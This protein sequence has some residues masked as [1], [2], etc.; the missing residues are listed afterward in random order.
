MVILQHWGSLGDVFHFLGR[1][2][3][4]S[5]GSV[6]TFAQSKL[7]R[8]LR[9]CWAF[10]WSWCGREYKQQGIPLSVLCLDFCLLSS[11]FPFPLH[12]SHHMIRIATHLY[13]MQASWGTVMS[14]KYW[15]KLVQTWMRRI[16]CVFCSWSLKPAGVHSRFFWLVYLDEKDESGTSG[17]N[18]ERR[19]I[20]RKPSARQPILF[21]FCFFSRLL[22]LALVLFSWFYL[23]S[24]FIWFCWSLSWGKAERVWAKVCFC[25]LFV[26][27]VVFGVCSSFVFLC[28]SAPL[29]LLHASTPLSSHIQFQNT[30]LHKA[31][32]EGR[33]H[34]LG[35]LL[36]AGANVNAKSKVCL[37]LLYC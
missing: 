29:L 7:W 22:W 31:V 36:D 14:Y 8:A 6:H 13:T 32:Q 24:F 37:V 16:M 10:D 9:C 17:V 34:V 18:Q 23:F 2:L 28:P 33:G 20:E 11:L 30:P 3:I 21:V 27:L 35:Q 19:E 26:F 1:S 5:S 25:P 15:S 12:H 4:I